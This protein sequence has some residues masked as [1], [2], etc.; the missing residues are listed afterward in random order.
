MPALEW[1]LGK[2]NTTQP[3]TDYDLSSKQINTQIEC[4]L[5]RRIASLGKWQLIWDL[6]DAVSSQQRA[7]KMMFQK[8]GTVYTKA[9]T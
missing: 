6:Q 8:V 9:L 1:V 7:G 5:Q 4:I 3:H 2:Q